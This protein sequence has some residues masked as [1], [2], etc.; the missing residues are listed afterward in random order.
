M[1]HPERRGLVVVVTTAPVARRHVSDALEAEGWSVLTL[2]DCEELYELVELLGAHRGRAASLKLVVA[3][4]TVPGASV[5]EVAAWARLKGLAVPFVLFAAREDE[6]M[7]DL[8]RAL[9]GV[10]VV[11]ASSLARARLVVR[12]TLAGLD[13]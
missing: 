10:T 7:K 5:F 13:A 6:R 12:E 2:H 1:S 11:T 3:D 9:G 8:A 4:T